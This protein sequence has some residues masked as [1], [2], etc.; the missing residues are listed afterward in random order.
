MSAE[1]LPHARW[2]EDLL[3][4]AR[5]AF[6]VGHVLCTCEGRYH[7]LWGSLRAAEVANSLKA[8]EPLLASLIAPLI[9]DKARVMIGGA[10]DPGVPCV[11]GRIYAPRRPSM[12]VI[13][14]CPAPLEIIREF[15][16]AKGLACRTMN[17]NLLDLDGAE[18]WDQ[19]V[20]HY[21]SEFVET[22]LHDRFFESLAHSLAPGGTLVCA[23]MTGTRVAGGHHDELGHIYFDYS[24]KALKNSP[25]ADLTEAPGF[26]QLL[27]SYSARWGHQKANL[28]TT[29]ELRE[30][31]R[32]A[33]LRILSESHTPRR[34][35]FVG[36]AA[37][38]DSSSL[39]VASH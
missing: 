1:P 7:T 5:R 35:R 32:G 3:W 36:G 2:T 18:Q 26:A 4:Q 15:T 31:M 38:I 12:T 17:L 6:A 25:L 23:A 11:V 24:L 29:D 13:D 8:E 22:R 30:S 39:I 21:T 9:R 27:R 10:A 37:I 16:A 20:L 28:P 33:G 34:R 14:R 19:I